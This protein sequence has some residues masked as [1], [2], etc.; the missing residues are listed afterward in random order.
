VDVLVG[1]LEF[2]SGEEGREADMLGHLLRTAT[3]ETVREHFRGVDLGPLVGA[4]DGRTTV[5]TGEQVTAR[6]FL[7]GLPSLDGA[8]VYDQTCERF[9][10]TTDGQ[11]ASAIE[12]AL[13]GL[14]LAR[15]ISKESDDGQTIYG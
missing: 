10:A 15:R 9:D 12:L 11:R 8:D 2:E 1:K 14:Y 13:E 6:E 5:T 7:S 4:L 3:A